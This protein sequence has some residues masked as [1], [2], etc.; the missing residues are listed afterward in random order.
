MPPLRF[1]TRPG[2]DLIIHI[3]FVETFPYAATLVLLNLTWQKFDW[4]LLVVG[5]GASFMAQI[6]QQIRDAPIDSLHEQTFTT[7]IGTENAVI[8][9][10]A[11]AIFTMGFG[12]YHLLVGNIPWIVAPLGLLA[13][14]A[15][16]LRLFRK[17]N[18]GRPETLIR[19]IVY[20]SFGYIAFLFLYAIFA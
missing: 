16:A 18:Q 12:F 7:K 4:I 6:E 2:L 11:G 14:P 20:L 3:L 19:I 5:A 9:L 1:K 8:L 17:P 10:K 13:V 15:V